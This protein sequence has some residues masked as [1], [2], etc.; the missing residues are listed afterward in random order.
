M[1]VQVNIGFLSSIT[2]QRYP[3]GHHHMEG[4]VGRVSFWVLAVAMPA[5]LPFCSAVV[6]SWAMQA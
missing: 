6:C 1:K 5:A 3:P 4:A 2:H